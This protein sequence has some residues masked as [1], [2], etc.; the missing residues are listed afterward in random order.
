MNENFEIHN[1]SHNGYSIQAKFLVRNGIYSSY[2]YIVF[3][4]KKAIND[5][6]TKSFREK[7]EQI[8]KEHCDIKNSN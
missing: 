7:I 4:G 2:S 6:L 8:L 3:D 1:I 5:L